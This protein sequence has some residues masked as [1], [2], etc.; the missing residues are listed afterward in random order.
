M[1]PITKLI[2]T[3]YF[4]ASVLSITTCSKHFQIH[5]LYPLHR[6]SVTPINI[7]TSSLFHFKNST[8]KLLSFT[9]YFRF[10][11]DYIYYFLIGKAFKC[12]NFIFW[13]IR[14]LDY[15]RRVQDFKMLRTKTNLYQTL[16]RRE[17]TS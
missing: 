5:L 11:K 17:A 16:G 8:K 6:N 3:L 2:L 14:F 7:I 9:E 10:L 1:L 12:S 4:V 13:V 15:Q